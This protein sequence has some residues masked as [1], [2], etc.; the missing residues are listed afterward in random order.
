MTSRYGFDRVSSFFAA[1]SSE[2]F[3]VIFELSI[4]LTLISFSPLSCCCFSASSQAVARLSVKPAGRRHKID[5]IM[6]HFWLQSAGGGSLWLVS[7][8]DVLQATK[9]SFI[10]FCEVSLFWFSVSRHHSQ[11]KWLK[12]HVFYNIPIWSFSVCSIG[13]TTV[14][15]RARGDWSPNF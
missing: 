1:S 7:W 3:A 10:K 2:L 14:G 11:M 15:T 9:P 12:N 6:F 5:N 4:I 13:A 8:S